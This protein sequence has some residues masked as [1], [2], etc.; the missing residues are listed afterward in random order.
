MLPF[1][2]M[3]FVFLPGRLITLSLI[4]ACNCLIANAQLTGDPKS[5][6]GMEVVPTVEAKVL[7]NMELIPL[8]NFSSPMKIDSLSTKKNYVNIR[9]SF[10]ARIH[11]KHLLAVSDAKKYYDDLIDR[12]PDNVLAR[13]LRAN[14]LKYSESRIAMQDCDH[15]IKIDP[16]CEFAYHVR[17]W[18]Y[19]RS[20]V[21]TPGTEQHVNRYDDAIADFEKAIELNKDFAGP[22]FGI[23]LI[24]YIRNNH[25]LAVEEYTKA[26]EI[27]P[28]GSY[29]RWRA[30]AR[31]SLKE[32]EAA[33]KDR[34]EAVRLD[35]QDP[36]NLYALGFHLT[37]GE[38][39]DLE[40][41][42]KL[43]V[44]ACEIDDWKNS[45]FSDA[46]RKVYKKTGNSEKLEWLQ[47]K[48]TRR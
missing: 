27:L 42:E 39:S 36:W 38:I 7:G 3:I 41:A 30:S 9:E 5:W 44:K 23:G 33:Q 10:P 40:R 14:L 8:H 45:S 24:N 16:K 31:S 32:G 28:K 1:P 17:G 2:R 19:Y 47:E 35:D 18:I 22:H 37:N 13:C 11:T 43:L 46:L 29:Y 21:V 12:E 34:E 25:K 20:I 4:L 15:A 48:V 26:I 6:V